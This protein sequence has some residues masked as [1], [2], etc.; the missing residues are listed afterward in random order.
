[1]SHQL[2]S[3]LLIYRFA[4]FVSRDYHRRCLLLSSN[5]PT[6][7]LQALSLTIISHAPQQPIPSFPSA[8]SSWDLFY[9][10]P[11]S[12]AMTKW[13]LSIS[14]I[15]ICQ[16]RVPSAILKITLVLVMNTIEFRTGSVGPG[17]TSGS[18]LD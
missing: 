17:V 4:K 16:L 5:S 13:I 15:R 2:A 7:P 18:A 9:N 1:M 14:T 3:H 12:L 11:W 10:I 6:P 8:E